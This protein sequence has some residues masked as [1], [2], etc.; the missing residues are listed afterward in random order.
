MLTPDCLDEILMLFVISFLSLG[1]SGWLCSSGKFVLQQTLGKLLLEVQI[2][3]FFDND[4]P[5]CCLKVKFCT[6]DHVVI[7]VL[8]P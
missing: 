5:Q 2:N 3:N 8:A 7:K 1:S 6:N 4:S